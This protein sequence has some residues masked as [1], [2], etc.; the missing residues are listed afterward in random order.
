MLV[1]IQAVDEHEFADR[2]AD[3]TGGM[4]FDRAIVEQQ[5]HVRREIAARQKSQTPLL[6]DDS[7][8]PPE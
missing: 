7:Q 1:T 8:R 6:E 3:W 2:P 5:G 4:L